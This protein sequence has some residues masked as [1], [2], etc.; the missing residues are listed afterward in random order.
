MSE[1]TR[2]AI[3]WL[4][5]RFTLW[6]VNRNLRKTHEAEFREYIEELERLMNRRIPPPQRAELRSW[7]GGCEKQAK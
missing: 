2:T 5:Y 4:R 6:R 1:A 7:Y 3:S